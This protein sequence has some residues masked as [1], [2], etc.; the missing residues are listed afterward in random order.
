MQ[1]V[2]AETRRRYWIPWNRSYRQL[3]T[4]VWVLEAGPL[5]EQTVPL[6]T[7]PFL[8]PLS[9]SF[10]SLEKLAVF[11]CTSYQY[12]YHTLEK[13]LYLILSSCLTMAGFMIAQMRS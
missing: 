9:K 7:E 5:E 1:E 4:T 3:L 8:Q 6:N 10:M 13:E 2:P 12:Y 11:P